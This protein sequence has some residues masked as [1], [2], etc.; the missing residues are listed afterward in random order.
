MAR[1]R[2]RE[3]RSHAG[4]PPAVNAGES[5]TLLAV[6]EEAPPAPP[7]WSGEAG[8]PGGGVPAY[9]P[10]VHDEPPSGRTLVERVLEARSFPFLRLLFYYVVLVTVMSLL[11]YHVPAVREAF[12]SP[13]ALAMEEGG[14]LVGPVGEDFGARV[15]L[16][17]ALRRALG[18]LL[19]ILGALSLVLPV[20]WVYM[21]TKRFRYDPALVSSVIILPIVVAGIALV[22][23]NSIAL[24]FALAGI[25]AAV[26]FRNT[27]KDPRDA[28]YIFLV[29][30]IG[31]SS[32]VQALDVA[33]V[34]SLAFNYVV[35][36]VW[37]FNV[38]SIYS[39][40]YA[41]TGIL[42]AGP[43]RLLVAQDPQGQ[44]EVRRRMLDHA[45]EIRTEGILLVHST[46]PD[47]ARHTVQ[48]ALADMARDWQLVDVV[49]RE[50]GMFTL[51]YLVRLKRAASP[52]E[53][54][55]ALDERW[56]AQVAA[57]EYLP[58]R[59]RRKK[60]KKR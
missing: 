28:V 32:G 23:K 56:G 45:A 21:L 1:N 19:V 9:R 20:A 25:V 42:S 3:S 27:L 44:S 26:R 52:P 14:G 15:S 43:Q 50:D 17:E 4:P 30:G 22:V 34:M 47:M 7:R 46:T 33:L 5:E 37:K 11:V 49:Q 59:A 18:T 39:G 54:V 35:L 48:E 10:P 57:A 53:L 60:R 12:L 31:L 13:Q 8:A 2:D 41:R 55:G 51:E 58:F 36:L 38:G 24:A 29:I 40:R 6:P 16:N